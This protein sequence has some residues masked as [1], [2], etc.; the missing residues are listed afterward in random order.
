MPMTRK[1]S[2]ETAFQLKLTS[3]FSPVSGKVIRLPNRVESVNG[4]MRAAA[5]A[6]IPG[7]ACSSGSA[8]ST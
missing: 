1:K 4:T 5:A 7:S 2:G 3:A 8:R 6:E